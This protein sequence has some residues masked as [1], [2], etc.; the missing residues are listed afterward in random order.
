MPLSAKSSPKRCPTEN[1]STAFGHPMPREEHLLKRWETPDVSSGAKGAVEFLSTHHGLFQSL[2]CSRDV[3]KKPTTWRLNQQGT[4]SEPNL[5]RCWKAKERSKSYSG[6]RR[7]RNFK[8]QEQVGRFWRLLCVDQG[9]KR[10]QC[11]EHQRWLQWWFDAGEGEECERGD[12]WIGFRAS[13]VKMWKM[14]HLVA[15]VIQS[16]S[17]V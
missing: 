11:E 7:F 16:A 3:T 6:V 17:Y 15:A 2:P 14:F 12:T 5:R 9:D 1:Y 10:Q 13:S 4:T 8:V